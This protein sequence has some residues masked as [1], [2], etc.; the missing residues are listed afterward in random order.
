MFV[1]QITRPSVAFTRTLG[2]YA[3]T[4]QADGLKTSV[5]FLGGDATELAGTVRRARHALPDKVTIGISTDG[6][7]GPG[8]YGLNREVTL[9]VLLASEGKVKFNAALIDP[10]IPV[11]LPKALSAICD[12][13]GGQPPSVESLMGRT[14]TS[15]S[16]GDAAMVPNDQVPG[17]SKIEP[18]VR[19]LIRK[20]TS[21]QRVDE[22]AK[23]ID[24]HLKDAPEAKQRLKE[25]AGRVYN[26]Y[27]T[28]HA[29]KHLRRW[30][31]VDEKKDEVDQPE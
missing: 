24:Q 14:E 31:G 30:A 23:Q 1:H 5:V 2:Q 26:I 13:V 6:L 9:T 7:E 29:K 19:M 18:L 16:T 20:E 8:A 12:A 3:A 21:D 17:F 27:G 22:L 25:I 11:E 15:R 4:R 10:S 28:D